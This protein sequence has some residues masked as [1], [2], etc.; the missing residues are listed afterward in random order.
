MRDFVPR[1]HGV[2]TDSLKTCM[3]GTRPAM[4]QINPLCAAKRSRRVRAV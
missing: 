1:I 2:L 3:A 4:M